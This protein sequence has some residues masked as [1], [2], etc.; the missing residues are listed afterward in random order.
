MKIHWASQSFV[1]SPIIRLKM[2]I[3]HWASGFPLLSPNT[4]MAAFGAGRL[5]P[6]EPPGIASRPLDR[7]AVISG[8]TCRWSRCRTFWY[9][10]QPWTALK[11]CCQKNDTR[12]FIKSGAPHAREISLRV[13][14]KIIKWPEPSL[15]WTISRTWPSTWCW[16][17][18]DYYETAQ[19]WFQMITIKQK[20]G[21][22]N[23]NNQGY[24][25]YFPEGR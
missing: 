25:R 11:I 12:V 20:K 19:N 1:Y 10:G 15:R 3:I 9:A 8:L 16:N 2:Q 24:F 4:S 5:R 18:N 14:W 7:A 23:G 21:G 6:S 13:K 17:R 22:P